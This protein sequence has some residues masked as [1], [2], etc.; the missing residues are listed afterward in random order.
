MTFEEKLAKSLE[1]ID[2][3]ADSILSKSDEP[4]KVEEEDKVQ[5]GVAPD[6]ISSNSDDAGK[7]EGD[8]DE[9][10]EEGKDD[11]KKKDDKGDDA[12]KSIT[13]EFTGSEAISKA[14]DVSDFL[15]EF[16]RVNGDVLD[17][18]REDIHKSLETST[19]TATI[20]AKSF[21]AIMKSHEGLEGLVKSQSAQL[22]EQAEIIKSLQG[23]VEHVEKQ[24]VVR[25]SVINT[26][27]K[28]FDHSAGITSEAEPKQE[29]LSKGEIA[30]KLS[31]FAL[32]GENGVVIKD[33]IDFESN[34]YLRPEVKNL[35]EPKQ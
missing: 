17:N 16:T 32:N 3:L 22:T 1:E 26:L 7:K 13:D 15:A 11:D 9:D 30:E 4:E 14:M 8:E 20:L 34:G 27:E 29:T 31:N 28:S 21:G 5:K 19:H 12:K 33:V 6:E 23:R 25:K 35:F 24:P 10:D 2:A 18:L